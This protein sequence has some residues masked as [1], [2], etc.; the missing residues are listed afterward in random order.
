MT[1]PRTTPRTRPADVYQIP[2][3]Y[4]SSPYS[5]YSRN[6]I[7]PEDDFDYE[8]EL[9]YRSMPRDMD[10][11]IPRTPSNKTRRVPTTSAKRQRQI[12]YPARRTADYAPRTRAYGPRI[13][14]SNSYTSWDHPSYPRSYDY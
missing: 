1:T 9:Y 11:E 12:P 3:D 10:F 7:V 2:R 8:P 5:R 6:Q 13:K 14:P 4:Y